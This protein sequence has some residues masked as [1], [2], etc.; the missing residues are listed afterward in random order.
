MDI[1][2]YINVSI[3]EKSKKI[4]KIGLWGVCGIVSE[5]MPCEQLILTYMPYWDT[6]TDVWFWGVIGLFLSLIKFIWKLGI[7]SS[8]KMCTGRN[9]WNTI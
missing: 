6:Y 4:L 3:S 9:Y 2:Q 5:H 8:K 1:D 7:D